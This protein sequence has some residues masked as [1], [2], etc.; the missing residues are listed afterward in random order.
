MA[1]L[2]SGKMSKFWNAPVPMMPVGDHWCT[3][4]SPSLAVIRW[5]AIVEGADILCGSRIVSPPQRPRHS[6][7]FRRKVSPPYQMMRAGHGDDV[8]VVVSMPES[9]GGDDRGRGRLV[10]P[11]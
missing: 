4:P 11:G 6:E 7:A 2:P 3:P 1:R 8:P 10:Q 9:S 5:C